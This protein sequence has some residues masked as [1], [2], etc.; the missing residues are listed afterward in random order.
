MIRLTV[1]TENTVSCDG[2]T[3]EHGVSFYIETPHHRIL[4]DMGQS[5]LFVRHAQQLGVDL[6]AVDVAVLSHGHYDHGGGLSYFLQQNDRARIFVNAHAFEPH[7]RADG[8]DI[9]LDP[10]L[11][12]HPRVIP[13]RDQLELDGE[14]S[15]CSCND[16]PCFHGIDTAG[17]CMAHMAPEDFRHEQYLQIHDAGR[18]I[19][20][21]G[22]SHKGILNIVEWFTPDVLVG[23]MH[24]N[25]YATTGAESAA[26]AQIARQLAATTTRYYTCH[27]TG[28]AQYAFLQTHLGEKISYLAAGATVTV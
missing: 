25:K 22:C 26:L 1:L 20:V 15:L 14:L 18:R 28:L 9:G 10:R 6:A 19:L 24:L 5:D 4:F 7:Y 16:R 3:P 27:C 13:V 21:S 2:L 17:L 23:G 8:S 11:Q 12:T